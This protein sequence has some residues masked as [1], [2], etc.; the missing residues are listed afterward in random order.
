MQKAVFM[1]KNSDR[2]IIKSSKTYNL[3]EIDMNIYHKGINKLI[4]FIKKAP[5]NWENNID[6]ELKDITTEL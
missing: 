4:H 5:N 2:L 3:Y 6:S 1:I